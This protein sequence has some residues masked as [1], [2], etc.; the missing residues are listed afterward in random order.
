[1]TLIHIAEGL[2]VEL[3]LPVFTTWVYCG[4]DSNTQPALTHCSTAADTRNL[5]TKCFESAVPANFVSYAHT[6]FESLLSED[7][8]YQ[9]WLSMK[10]RPVVLEKKIFLCKNNFSKYIFL[11]ISSEF[12]YLKLGNAKLGDSNFI[13]TSG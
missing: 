12:I 10:A 7:I 11:V 4:W 5:N 13:T 2:A 1:M 6:F 8:L 3:S 9:V